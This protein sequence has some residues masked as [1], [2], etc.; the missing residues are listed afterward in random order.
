MIGRRTGAIALALALAGAG[1]IAVEALG[2]RPYSRLWNDWRAL[3]L[4]ERQQYR[5]EYAALQSRK[6]SDTMLRRARQFSGL[7]AAEQARLY[8][9]NKQ[10]KKMVDSLSPP[11]REHFRTLSGPVQAARALEWLMQNDAA[12]LQRIANGRQPH[13]AP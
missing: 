3:P 1:V 2:E 9:A 6:L 8:E 11:A 12:A 13:G 7:N 5:L 4:Y 10:I